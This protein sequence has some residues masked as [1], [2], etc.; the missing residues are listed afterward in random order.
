ML[1]GRLPNFG[2]A[3]PFV[4]YTFNVIF[5]RHVWI[6]LW[7]KNIFGRLVQ[8]GAWRMVGQN[9]FLPGPSDTFYRY[10]NGMSKLSGVFILILTNMDLVKY[11]TIS[12]VLVQT[13]WS[14][15]TTAK[16]WNSQNFC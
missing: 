11:I 9:H 12:N 4:F 7:Q 10:F 6:K 15:A 8:F 16:I 14:D 2:K 3:K 1:P 5:L 13:F